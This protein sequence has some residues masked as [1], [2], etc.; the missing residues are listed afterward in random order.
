VKIQKEKG[1]QDVVTGGLS[2][3]LLLCPLA[4]ACKLGLLVFSTTMTIGI[5]PLPRIDD[6]FD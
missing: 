4:L 3:K 5:N 6:L 2:P 1:M